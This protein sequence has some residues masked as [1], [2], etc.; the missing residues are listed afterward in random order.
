MAKTQIYQIIKKGQTMSQEIWS[1]VDNYYTQLLIKPAPEFELANRDAS[2]EGLP[3][4]QITP[5]QGAL[6]ETLVRFGKVNRILEIGTL[7]GFSTAWLASGLGPDGKMIS[8]EIDPDHARVARENIDRFALE[9]EVEILVGD[10]RDLL[11]GL[12]DQGTP[13]FDLIFIDAAKDQYRDYLQL[14]L[15]LSREGTLI[16]A[17]NVVRRG[18]I[19]EHDCQDSSVKGIWEFNNFISAEPRLS[20]TVLQT[21][22]EKGYDGFAFLL[23]KD[24]SD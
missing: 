20:A 14:A 7:G 10:G 23:V 6:L 13:A 18:K 3:A 16:V 12:I 19:L 22:G 8:L 21:V 9:G 15:N 5:P 24:S 11:Q 4:I 2:Q 17:D 1:A